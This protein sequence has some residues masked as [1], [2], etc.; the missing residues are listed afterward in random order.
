MKKLLTTILFTLL[1]VFSFGCHE[2]YLNLISGPTDI[3]G[4]Q[5]STTVQVC[6]GQ[7]VNWGGTMDFTLT[8]AGATYVSY[9]PTTL[10]NTYN[11]YTSA[12]CGG[13]N[14]FMGGCG[15]VTANAGSSSTST[16]VTYSTTSSTPAGYPLVPDDNEECGGSPTSFCFN[17]TFVTNGYPTSITL[18]GNTEETTPTVCQV[19][20]GHSSTYAGGPCNGAYD[21]NM[22]LLFSVLPIELGFFGG[23]VSEGVTVI[24]WTTF[25]EIN[26]NYFTLERSGDGYKWEV[27]GTVEGAGNSSSIIDYTFYDRHP[28]KGVNYY[29]LKQTDYDGEYEYSDIISVKHIVKEKKLDRITNL[30][31]QTVTEDY[32]GIKVYIYTDG[33][34]EKIVTQK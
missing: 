25:S 14:C 32:S 12:S 22:T 28:L 23:Y 33:S 34:I 6:I 11:A 5:Y 19:V 9:S 30:M 16:V 31:G 10:S 15:S 27:I 29:K 26:N 3:G 17:F 20:C 7:T 24:N 18:A 21:A 1:T 2:T 8:V 4:G 13:P